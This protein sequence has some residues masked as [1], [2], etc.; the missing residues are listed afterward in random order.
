MCCRYRTGRTWES[1]AWR[2]LI[3]V[4]G[5]VVTTSRPTSR[6][7][8]QDRFFVLSVPSVRYY[9]LEYVRAPRQPFIFAHIF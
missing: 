6:L 9:K 2:I 1:T 8:D 3:E 5:D 4:A 7:T